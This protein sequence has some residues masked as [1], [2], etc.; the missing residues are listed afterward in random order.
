MK[1]ITLHEPWASWI[2]AGLKTIETRTHDRYKR[3]IGQR[4]AIHAGQRFDPDAISE[5]LCAYGPYGTMSGVVQ[6]RISDAAK[7]TRHG[8]VVCTA[9]IYAARWLGPGDSVDALITCE[10]GFS[11]IPLFGFFLT[12]VE[13][14]NDR[15]VYR[16]RQGTWEWE[17]RS[18]TQIGVDNRIPAEPNP[19]H[20]KGKQ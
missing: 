17:P 18:D 14:N 11:I 7:R 15:T 5:A 2:A 6:Y 16:G 3:L 13:V 1:A 20:R 19:P 8:E 4:I 10:L 12:D 9:H